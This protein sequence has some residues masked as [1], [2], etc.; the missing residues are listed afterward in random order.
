MGLYLSL[1]S[2]CVFGRGVRFPLAV[3]SFGSTRRSAAAALPSATSAPAQTRRRAW[4]FDREGSI[5]VAGA[6]YTSQALA[7]H[8]AR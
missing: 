3:G 6:I 4:V 8:R 5:V 7:R 1:R 2:W